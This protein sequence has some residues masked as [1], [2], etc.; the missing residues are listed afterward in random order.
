MRTNSPRENL[1]VRLDRPNVLL[2]KSTV[3]V[4]FRIVLNRKYGNEVSFWEMDGEIEKS[5]EAM[6]FLHPISIIG[7]FKYRP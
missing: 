1:P 5:N 2:N 6:G 3:T 4:L 7:P